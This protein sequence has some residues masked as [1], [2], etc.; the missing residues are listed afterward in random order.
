MGV[1]GTQRTPLRQ[2]PVKVYF[3]I[4]FSVLLFIVICEFF[5][6]SIHHLLFTLHIRHAIRFG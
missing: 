5:L 1:N 2:D 3:K 6:I 4:M